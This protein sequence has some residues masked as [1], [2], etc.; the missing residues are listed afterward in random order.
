MTALCCWIHLVDFFP[1]MRVLSQALMLLHQLMA[2]EVELV[3]NV[4]GQ[5]VIYLFI[6]LTFCASDI[7]TNS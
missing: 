7:V 1:T 2:N 3:M 4:K 5:S 6:W